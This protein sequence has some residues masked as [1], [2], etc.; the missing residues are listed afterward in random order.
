MQGGGGEG[1]RGREAATERD[2]GG[3]GGSREEKRKTGRSEGKS[4]TQIQLSA[5]LA[6]GPGERGEAGESERATGLPPLFVSSPASPFSLQGLS[7][8]SLRPPCRDAALGILRLKKKYIPPFSLSQLIRCFLV[9]PPLLQ[10]WRK[11]PPPSARSG[12]VTAS[13]HPS[14][15]NGGRRRSARWSI[16]LTPLSLPLPFKKHT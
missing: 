11:R 13:Q 2:D 8:L 7:L 9:P 3:G 4:I 10:A 5:E 14:A 16:S 6:A 12:E 1:V 15:V